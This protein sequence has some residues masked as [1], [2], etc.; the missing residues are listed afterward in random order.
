[1]LVQKQ[2]QDKW[3]EKEYCG[4]VV[5]SPITKKPVVI[6]ESAESAASKLAVLGG[7]ASKIPWKPAQI[8]GKVLGL[9]DFI[10]DTYKAAKEPSMGNTVSW[11]LD[12]PYNNVSK[13]KVD[14]FASTLGMYDDAS[15]VV[16]PLNGNGVGDALDRVA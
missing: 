5:I 10:I 3:Y 8:A 9:P 4:G 13:S 1:M 12:L 2:Q 16:E 11:M 6:R 14:E 15:S 7:I